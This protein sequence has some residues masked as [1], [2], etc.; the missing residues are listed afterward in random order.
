MKINNRIVS[1]CIT[2]TLIFSLSAVM[3]FNLTVSAAVPSDAIHIKTAAE[4]AA[5]GGEVSAGKYYVLDNDINLTAEWTPI[6]N[7]RGTFDG[8]GYSINNLYVLA[9]SSIK[10]CGAF[11]NNARSNRNTKKCRGKYR[12]ARHIRRLCRRRADR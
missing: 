5:I 7:F 2:L 10:I 11:R 12:F 1:L 3:S 8:Q 4:L 6:D 9:G